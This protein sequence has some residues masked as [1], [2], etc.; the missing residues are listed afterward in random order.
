MIWISVLAF[1][2]PSSFQTSHALFSKS[3]S[4]IL[5][6]FRQVSFADFLLADI[7]TSLARPLAHLERSVC[8][9]MNLQ[10]QMLLDDVLEQS[11]NRGAVHINLVLAAPFLIRMVQCL[12]IYKTENASLQLF[13]A[14][15]YLTVLP[16]IFSSVMKHH[17]QN[18]TAIEFWI[19]IWI[20]SSM[21]NTLFSYYWDLEMDWDIVWFRGGNGASPEFCPKIRS[22]AFYKPKWIYSFAM[23]TNFVIRIGWI[24][25]LSVH[26]HYSLAVHLVVSL[27]EVCRRCQWIFIRI[28]SGLR[29]LDR[30]LP[31]SSRADI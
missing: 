18:E 8:I 13:N 23:I 27:L 21:V 29:K 24:Y 10:N 30:P 15:K 16:V 4:R 19:Q 31:K 9:M 2:V 7:L 17:A 22:D 3:L 20:F 5:F 12:W 25:K 14:L 26:L 28:E 6:P 11:C 1:P